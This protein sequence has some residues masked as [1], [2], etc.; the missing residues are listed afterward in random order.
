VSCL[1]WAVPASGSDPEPLLE[2]LT[3]VVPSVE[4][5]GF[6]LTAQA[7]R[8]SLVA[9]KL[10]GRT[11]IVYSPGAGGLIG[12]AHFAG[13]YRGRGNALLVGGSF[14]L[15]AAAAM[16]SAVS[17]A[18][19]TPIA[20][21]TADVD[22]VV[23]P[24][25][26]P[27]RTI[28]DLIEAQHA[29]PNV[30]AWVGGSAGGPDQFLTWSIA[31]AGGIPAS[32]V[33]YTAL[34]GGSAVGRALAEGRFT[35]GVSGYSELAPLLDRGVLRPLAITGAS[36]L[37]ALPAVP[38]LS[39]SDI[40][41]TVVNWRGAFAPPGL[42]ADAHARLVELIDRMVASPRWRSSLE[43]HHWRDEYLQGESFARFVSDEHR[44]AESAAAQTDL[45]PTDA[46]SQDLA[47]FLA[48]RYQWALALGGLA[49][50]LGATLWL[51]ASRHRRAEDQLEVLAKATRRAV[52][53]EAALQLQVAAAAEQA[54]RHVLHEAQLRE[55]LE[56]AAVEARSRAAELENALNGIAA[57][58]GREF[59]RW[60]LSSA[61]REIAMLMLKGMSLKQI[62]RMRQT[63][64]RTVRQQA[65]AIYRKAGIE[66]RHDLSAHFIEDLLKPAA[67]P[68]PVPTQ[69]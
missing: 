14:M 64:E 3:I 69:L 5:G 50:L 54:R 68:L 35:V 56:R 32:Q 33:R 44:R 30:V 65:Q 49:L 36:R 16:R 42:G 38:T 6:D 17:P 62:A 7:I 26:S 51:T 25:D 55:A 58:I 10:V 47:R 2:S 24:S 27:L 43:H 57:L 21:L 39:E 48:R 8:E 66:G 34:P 22:A 41:V 52:Q 20:R 60:D 1:A 13:A 31:G 28:D 40:P 59:A 15:G 19:L 18:D 45:Q 11:D 29:S 61:E 9:E 46:T 37:Q 23:V 12:L 67:Q 63:S 53:E 4:G